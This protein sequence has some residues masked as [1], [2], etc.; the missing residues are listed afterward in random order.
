MGIP[1]YFKTLIQEYETEILKKDKLSQCNSLFLDLNCLIAILISYYMAIQFLQ[2][3]ME[4]R[5][6][7]HPHYYLI[8]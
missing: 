3:G 5:I 2:S 7:I 1:V 4:K 8:S 6:I